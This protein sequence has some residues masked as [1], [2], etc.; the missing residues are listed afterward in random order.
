MILRCIVVSKFVDDLLD[1]R[2]TCIAP[3][4]FH[5]NYIKTLYQECGIMLLC[6]MIATARCVRE[7]AYCQ[8]YGQC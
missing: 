1:H 7:A 6:T 2:S 4:G 5:S 8:C 3:V